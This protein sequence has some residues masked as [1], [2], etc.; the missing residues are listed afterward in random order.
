MLR[1]VAGQDVWVVEK[2]DAEIIRLFIHCSLGHHE[3]LMPLAAKLP[4]A[5]NVFFDLPGH[6]RS[7]PWSGTEY[8]SDAT[9]IAAGLLHGP[10]H[11]IG[12]SF[13]ATVALRLAAERPDLVSR[14]T[15]IEPVMFAAAYCMEAHAAH[16]LKMEPFIV[17][18]RAQDRYAAAQAFL[19]MWGDGSTWEDISER[20]RAALAARIHLI[21]AVFQAIEDDVH[22]L[23]AR[24]AYVTCP[25]DLIKGSDS[26]EIMA[27]II[28]GL[29]D[30][31]PHA[32][33]YEI[34]GAGHM[35]PITHVDAVA[36]VL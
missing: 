15:L 16:R 18:W 11:I 22:S 32:S 27:A 20:R 9:A 13:G 12:H 19:G 6:G 36:S 35:V 14:V 33:R 21:P 29:A 7:A 28:D 4:F 26:Q 34:N 30:R 1:H 17:A 10:T 31:M 23:L 5:H 24:L 2:G 25:V 8:H 3:T